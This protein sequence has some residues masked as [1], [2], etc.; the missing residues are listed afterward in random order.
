MSIDYVTWDFSCF[1]DRSAFSEVMERLVTEQEAKNRLTVIRCCDA[2]N[3]GDMHAVDELVADEFIEHDPMPTRMQGRDGMKATR[4][5]LAT[6][7][8]DFRFVIEDL[9]AENDLVFV[10]GELLGTHRGAF[11]DV[12]ATGNWVRVTGSCLLRLSQDRLIEGWTNVDMFGLLQQLDVIPVPATTE[13]HSEVAPQAG[14]ASGSPSAAKAVMQRMI[15][16][17]WNKGDLAVADE[18]F[19]P[20]ST[21]PTAPQAAP[22]PDGVK[23]IVSMFRSAFPDYWIHIEDM[24]ASGD[25]VAARFRQGGT[26]LGDLM[27]IPATG[28]S[29][30][31]TEMGMLRLTRGQIAESWYDV[32]MVGLFG[33]LGV[34]VSS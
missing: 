26:H 17:L 25:R 1:T 7:F 2:L 18:L 3:R 13:A 27:G 11:G 29:V 4:A 16:D 33:Q 14:Y 21:S 23:A 6:A 22:G 8:P 30:E 19:H 5:A 32:D 12:A 9:L 34:S 31:W 15:D 10:R 20:Q 24:V 28:R